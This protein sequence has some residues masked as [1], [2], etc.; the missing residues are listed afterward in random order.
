MSICSRNGL[1][2]SQRSAVGVGVPSARV[3]PEVERGVDD[4]VSLYG[5]DLPIL[6]TRL[7][8]PVRSGSLPVQPGL[9]LEV[10]LVDVSKP[11]RPKSHERMLVE[12][13]PGAENSRHTRLLK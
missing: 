10:P 2:V 4:R 3:S 13:D 1:R 9:V 12:A 6:A 7:S 5:V 11:G 8:T